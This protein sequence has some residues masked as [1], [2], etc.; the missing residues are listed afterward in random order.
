MHVPPTAGPFDYTS[1]SLAMSF[2]V[3]I[4]IAILIGFGRSR[5][6]IMRRDCCSC[7]STT[8]VKDTI[9]VVI[10]AIVNNG[11]S[12]QIHPSDE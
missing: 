3:F 4:I 5:R 10:F 8:T 7:I 6:G 12:I 1:Q 2:M 11:I 9:T